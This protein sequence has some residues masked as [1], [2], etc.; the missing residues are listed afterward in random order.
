MSKD[1]I[2]NLF[3]RL[4]KEFDI[5]Q[6]AL[7]HN[8]RFLEKLNNQSAPALIKEDKQWRRLWKP[9]V[10]VAAAV[11]LMVT[12]VFN[13]QNAAGRDLASVSPKMA[14]T[15]DFFLTSINEELF[16]LQNEK[17]PEVQVIVQDAMQRL[18]VLED[19][20]ETLKTDLSESGDDTRVIYAMISNF[21]NRI[22]I[23]KST[24][25]KI[26]HIKE[27]KNQSNA[28]NITI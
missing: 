6:P 20:Y 16:K 17:S 5:E 23:L 19:K 15:Q 18:K 9:L 2:D 3:N 8:V 13:N 4:E 21:Q 14:Q 1:N 25:E 11:L 22:D 10:G 26:N 27:L 24:I 12:F 7:N 28:T